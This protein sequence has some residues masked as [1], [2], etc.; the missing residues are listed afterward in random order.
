MKCKLYFT[1]S[2]EKFS[3]GPQLGLNAG[4]SN[5]EVVSLILTE[6]K[7]I[8]L[9]PGLLHLQNLSPFTPSTI[10]ISFHSTRVLRHIQTLVSG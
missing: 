4:R 5:L 10:H 2:A 6:F 7:H 3:R 1:L 8:V 9:I